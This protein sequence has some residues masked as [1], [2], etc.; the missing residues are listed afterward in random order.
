MFWCLSLRLDFSSDESKLRQQQ[1]ELEQSWVEVRQAVAGRE[2]VQ[3][4]LQQTQAQLDESKVNLEK[5]QSEK[6]SQQEH[7]EQ[8]EAAVT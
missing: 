8:G 2:E 4:S 7:N 6:L 3:Q 1:Q 5:L